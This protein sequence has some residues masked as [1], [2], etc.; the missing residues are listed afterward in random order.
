MGNADI[1]IIILILIGLIVDIFDI[2][3]TR[4]KDDEDSGRDSE[5]PG[6]NS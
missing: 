4:K 5:T 6:R 1:V 3:Y 2:R